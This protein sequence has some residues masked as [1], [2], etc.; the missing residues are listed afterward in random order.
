MRYPIYLVGLY[1]AC[2]LTA[3][4]TASKV[5]VLGPFSV[6]AAVYIFTLTYTLLDLINHTLGPQEARRVV[7]AGFI[8]NAVLA[9]YSL[10]AVQLPPAAGWP[11]QEAF[12]AVIGN[13]PR[14]VFASLV[15]YLVSSNMDVTA[16]AWLSRRTRPWARVLISNGVGLA[17]DTVL[18][19]T[20]AFAGVLP[21]WPVMIGQYSVKM[22]VTVLS[23]PLIYLARHIAE[24]GWQP[25]ES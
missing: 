10:F 11:A 24:E 16:Y 21:V 5:T 4:V 17:V 8:G 7:L 25:S 18:F 1:L 2:E 19:V 13:T 23:V 3:N 12:A 6:P 9:G 22:A 14:I 20:I 15:A